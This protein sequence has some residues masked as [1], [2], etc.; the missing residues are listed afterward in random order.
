MSG[1]EEEREG[2]D[3]APQM[4]FYGRPPM[5]VFSPSESSSRNIVSC[6][7]IE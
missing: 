2:T 4:R 3:R 1:G 6:A 5:N 7:G